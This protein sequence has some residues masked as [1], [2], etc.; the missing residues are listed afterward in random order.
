MLT[1]PVLV[2][3]A[4]YGFVT[5][6]VTFALFWI[7]KKASVKGSWRIPEA[8]LLFWTRLGGSVGA[9]LAQR[10]LRHKTRKQPFASDLNGVIRNQV[11]LAIICAVLIYVPGAGTFAKRIILG[12]GSILIA[13]T[14]PEPGEVHDNF[15]R[16][17]G[18][19][20]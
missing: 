1:I 3:L 12:A 16:R 8:R 18:P 10:I 6:V 7:D 19:G 14:E 2:G 15:P 11:F 5:N 17:F 9:K 4:V 13:V 20:S